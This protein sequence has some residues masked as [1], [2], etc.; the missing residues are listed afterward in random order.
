ML[1]AFVNQ[2]GLQEQAHRVRDR[3]DP[4]CRRRR[5]QRQDFYR[6]FVAPNDLVFDIGAN[7]GNRVETFVSLG[8]Q[9]VAVEPQS[10]C[11]AYLRRWYGRKPVTV[12][13]R[14]VGSA[15]GTAIL[16][17]STA[18]TLATFSQNYIAEATAAGLNAGHQWN[19]TEEVQVCTLD[20]L[21]SEYGN[22]RFCKIDVEGFELEVLRGVSQPLESLSFEFHADLD[23][24]NGCI[25]QLETLGRYRY[26]FALDESM[27]LALP[28]WADA[29]SLPGALSSAT[30]KDDWGD[31]YAVIDSAMA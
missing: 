7:M 10:M 9:V 27:H 1:R 13:P 2:L 4:A 3:V 19:A 5:S 31:I 28:K 25:A 11:V 29:E 14:G 26:N 6:Q 22:P 21:I 17:L 24:A 18:H 12:V 30:H 8:A 15:P 23:D 16:H 20:H